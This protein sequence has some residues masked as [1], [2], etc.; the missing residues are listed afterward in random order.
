M[1]NTAQPGRIKAMV[2]LVL[3]SGLAGFLG[4]G[5]GKGSVMELYHRFP[6]KTWARFNLLSFELPVKNAGSYNIYLFATIDQGFQYETLD[7]NMIMNT[8]AGEERIREYQLK[9]KTT[10]GD[11]CIPCSK[12]S[13]RG[14][15]LLKRELNISKPGI[16]KVE[17][18]NLTP[19]MRTEGVLGVGIRMEGSGK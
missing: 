2:L 18:E 19:H 12:D 3:F 8:S 16:L 5:C 7:F 17:I 14:E 10:A 9:I 4:S 11:F 1:A 13:C 6:D 15:I